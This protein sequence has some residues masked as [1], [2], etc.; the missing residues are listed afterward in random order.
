M[1]LESGDEKP[2]TAVEVVCTEEG[3]REVIAQVCELGVAGGRREQR[4]SRRAREGQGAREQGARR[5]AVGRRCRGGRGRSGRRPAQMGCRREAAER[6][7]LAGENERAREPERAGENESG[8]GAETVGETTRRERVEDPRR[9]RR[10]TKPRPPPLD[11]PVGAS[12]RQAHTPAGS[13]M[14]VRSPS[15]QGR[16]GRQAPHRR[17]QPLARHARS[18]PNTRS[19][20]A[21]R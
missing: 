9:R 6:R 3:R 13:R 7:R 17:T 20:H 8:R 12:R 4:G 16:R 21:P 15:G 14:L 18:Q 5:A 1:R 10:S 11:R 19:A 2:S